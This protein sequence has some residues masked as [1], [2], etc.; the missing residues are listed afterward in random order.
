MWWFLSQIEHLVQNYVF[1]TLGC[2]WARSLGAQCSFCKG[3]PRVIQPGTQELKHSSTFQGNWKS[4][5]ENWDCLET[6]GILGRACLMT[7]TANSRIHSPAPVAW[8][9]WNV[10]ACWICNG[11]ILLA[12][13]VFL[14][15]FP[16]ARNRKRTE[17]S[18]NKFYIEWREAIPKNSSDVC[19]SGWLPW[20]R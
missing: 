6:K 5:T 11:I 7:W 10:G 20:W 16:E 19:D 14:W 12:N 18:L 9:E 15:D 4:V 3:S 1:V 8:A 2:S 13:P 17:G